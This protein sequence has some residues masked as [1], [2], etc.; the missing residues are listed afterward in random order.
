[1][2][3]PTKVTLDS[4]PVATV[5]EGQKKLGQTPLELTVAQESRR[6]RLTAKRFAATPVTLNPGQRGQLPTVY[7][8]RPAYLTLRAHPGASEIW[9]NGQ[10]VGTGSLYRFATDLVDIHLRSGIIA[11]ER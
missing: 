5:W 11:M 7:L 10:K 4:I 2:A 6:L 3:R 8:N 1:M 9:L